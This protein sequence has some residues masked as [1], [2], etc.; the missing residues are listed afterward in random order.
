MLNDNTAKI[1]K[2]NHKYQDTL[3]L[4]YRVSL[5]LPSK[6]VKSAYIN[7]AS[8]ELNVPVGEVREYLQ[9]LE[10][11]KLIEETTDER[12]ILGENAEKYVPEHIKKEFVQ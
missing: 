7:M 6:I 10:I 1:L 11:L 2:E 9:I 4:F 5:G 3:N 8:K 12:L